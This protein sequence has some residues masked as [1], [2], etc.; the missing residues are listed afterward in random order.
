M[1]EI[2][3]KINIKTEVTII[4]A[5]LAGSIAA[6]VLAKKTSSLILLDKQ[7]FPRKKACGEGLSE[8]G[9][10]YLEQLGL[11]NE[12]LT[13][14]SVEFRGYQIR[15]NNGQASV[16]TNKTSTEG[17]CISREALDNQVHT[18]AVGNK[19]V[20]RIYENASSFKFVN[21]TYQIESEKHIINSEFLILAAGSLGTQNL[22]SYGE[23]ENN[24]KRFGLA[25]WAKG[26]W[27][28]ARPNLV[29]INNLAGCQ[30]I[31]T[32]L[33][34]NEVNISILVLKG[35][36]NLKTQEYL[37]QAKAICEREGFKIQSTSKVLGAS[38]IDKTKEQDLGNNCYF[39]GDA[40]EQFDPVG[41]MGMTHAI[42][43]ASLAAN[44]IASVINRE[45]SAKL[46]KNDYSSKRNKAARILRLLTSLSYGLNVKENPFAVLFTSKFPIVAFYLTRLIKSFF[47]KPASILSQTNT[48][49]RKN[50]IHQ[51][52]GNMILRSINNHLLFK[53][54]V[55]M[56]NIISLISILITLF[57]SLHIAAEESQAVSA[58]NS[59][60]LPITLSDKNAKIN[61]EVD[62]TWHLVKG[63]TKNISGSVA[64]DS[65]GNGKANQL[66]IS[67]LIP[68]KDFDTD[69]SMRDDKMRTVMNAEKFP[70]VKFEANTE[71]K[72]CTAEIT[73]RQSS[74]E[75][76][77]SGNL[78]IKD[79][80]LPIK[81]PIK[82]SYK[83]ERFE[84]S[85]KTS[86]DWS[87]FGVEDPSILIAKL[88][89]IVNIYIKIEL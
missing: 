41:G 38:V 78:T 56:R 39:V 1:I 26:N 49:Q 69:S 67:V 48:H 66:K 72:T 3:K 59:W 53:G 74:C 76:T 6:N 80:T 61:F 27:E 50:I 40:I 51:F 24:V 28:I 21:G 46:A 77:I 15:H 84:I 83:D 12:D 20:R 85:A 31:I 82:F 47:P 86:L 55:K 52:N 58:K 14:N 65:D 43:S 22:L 42:Y 54:T 36:S 16:I 88:D 33:S 25:L 75:E 8:I 7:N 44:K 37:N 17:Y 87:D 34:E 64:N 79:K 4:G 73:A 5:S 62:S 29:L 71:L 11:W 89:K 10:N 57:F 32:P 18:Q 13:T 2:S 60:G 45:A 63:T 81:L 19:N 9:K 35:Q 30:Y 70:N 68:V 23:R